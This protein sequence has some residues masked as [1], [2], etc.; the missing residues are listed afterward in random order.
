M[1]PVSLAL[2]G[3]LGLALALLTAC[4]APSNSTMAPTTAGAASGRVQVTMAAY[5]TPAE[6]Y[7]RIIPLFQADYKARTGQEVTFATSYAGSGAQSR[8]VIGGLEAD[9]VAL[10]L[11]PDV[12]NIAKAK[13][14]THDW[15]TAEHNGMVSN[16]VVV[17]AV[18]QGNPRAIRD[19]ADLTQAGLN[20][21]TPDAATSGGAR[22][23]IL[24]LYGAALRGQVAGV[25]KD[26]PQAAQDLLASVLKNVTVF[27]KDARTS[28]TTFEKG[29]GDV[30]I[31]YE[32]EV[33][34]GR[35]RGQD[36]ELVIPHSTILIETPVAVVDA[37][38][39]KHGNRAAAEAFVSFLF[40]RP[41]QQVFAQFGFR[42]VD[43]AVAQD[44][45]SQYPAVT[46]PFTVGQ[47]GG[48]GQANQDLFD[49]DTGAY[50]LALAAAQ[51]K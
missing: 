31:T 20:V 35:Q 12:D 50:Y 42:P 11:A 8:A 5:S 17:F 46:D 38:A 44:T 33:L 49:Q 47:F 30:A 4:G 26:D 37:N 45:A 2:R 13:L 40:T 10:A 14:I 39:G 16:S 1:K 24:G 6:A 25:A 34:L 23:D 32:N 19:W 7:A 9:V 48:W 21:L 51:G 29:I 22:W 28:V 41:A 15:T 43:P 27:D 36:Y 3:L 18:R